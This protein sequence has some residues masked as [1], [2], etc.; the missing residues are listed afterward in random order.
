R[1]PR[2]LPPPP[3]APATNWGRAASGIAPAATSNEC[4]GSVAV[5]LL[6][7]T[8]QRTTSVETAHARVRPLWVAATAATGR[9]PLAGVDFSVPFVRSQTLTSPLLADGSTLPLAEARVA[10]LP[11]RA[12]EWASPAW[13]LSVYLLFSAGSSHTFP[14]PSQLADANRLSPQNA[15]DAT[16]LVCSFSRVLVLGVTAAPPPPADGAVSVFGLAIC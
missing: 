3:P 7:F 12:T 6:P 5:C 11:R 13:P 10:P 15:S 14:V 1:T 4:P 9:S 16:S 8:S 2:R